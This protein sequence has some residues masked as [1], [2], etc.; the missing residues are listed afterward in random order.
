MH[1][2]GR[3]G[4]WEQTKWNRWNPV[5]YGPKNRATKGEKKKSK[6]MKR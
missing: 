1:E 2:E 3:R 6:N 4:K 5:S